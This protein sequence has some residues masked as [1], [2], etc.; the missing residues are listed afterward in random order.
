MN[1]PL[2]I[3]VAILLIPF[4]VVFLLLMLLAVF[5]ALPISILEKQC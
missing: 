2:K 5:L 4:T 1:K 3:F